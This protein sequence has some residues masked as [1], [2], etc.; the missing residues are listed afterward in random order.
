MERTGSRCSGL[1]GE[2]AVE[3]VLEAQAAKQL[4]AQAAGVGVDA[5]FEALE[6]QAV[7]AG[8]GGGVAGA[9][10]L[11]GAADEVAAV[12][13]VWRSVLELAGEVE[14]EGAAEVEGLALA[15]G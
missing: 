9:A 12:V 7:A 4:P 3:D 1:A 10:E 14:G 6:A 15:G 2:L 13:G 8:D 5:V 11:E